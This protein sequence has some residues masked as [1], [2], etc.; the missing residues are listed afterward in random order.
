MLLAVASVVSVLTVSLVRMDPASSLNQNLIRH[1][2][3]HVGDSRSGNAPEAGGA[4]DPDCK[5]R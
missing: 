1:T 4:L 3:E 2:R 5:H